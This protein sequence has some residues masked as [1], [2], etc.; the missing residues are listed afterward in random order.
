L[1]SD[2]NKLGQHAPI[3]AVAFGRP[4]IV[5]VPLAAGCH[6]RRWRHQFANEVL[7]ARFQVIELS[8]VCATLVSTTAAASIAFDHRNARSADSGA[9]GEFLIRRIIMM[10]VIIIVAAA[11][12]GA[13]N[14]RAQMYHLSGRTIWR[15]AAEIKCTGNESQVRAGHFHSYR[16]RPGSTR[17]LAGAQPTNLHPPPPPR[18]D[19]RPAGH[20][21][22]VSAASR[23]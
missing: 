3:G 16:A 6:C 11:G 7:A 10:S 12:T 4:S 21:G 9:L 14:G 18:H 5:L 8:P 1:A 15:P 13:F 17:A 2:W 20:G 23:R 19:G 22:L